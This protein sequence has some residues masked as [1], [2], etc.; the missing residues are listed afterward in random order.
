MTEAELAIALDCPLGTV[1]RWLRSRC[2]I[3]SKYSEKLR[4]L[5]RQHHKGLNSYVEARAST[6][7]LKAH[8]LHN[9]NHRNIGL[10]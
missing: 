5:R 4:E 6:R 3:R 10:K 7:L 8:A 9:S 2:T 1:K